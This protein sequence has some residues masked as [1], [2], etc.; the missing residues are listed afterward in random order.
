MTERIELPA[1]QDAVQTIRIVKLYFREQSQL[2]KKKR[3]PVLFTG[4]GEGRVTRT[5]R[6]FV[7]YMMPDGFIGHHITIYSCKKLQEG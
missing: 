7:C 3:S 2:I 5:G 4:G 6:S 1:V